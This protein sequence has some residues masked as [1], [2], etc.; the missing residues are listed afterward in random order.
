MG[1]PPRKIGCEEPDELRVRR[2]VRERWIEKGPQRI[3][4]GPQLVAALFHAF[5]REDL[6]SPCSG[7]VKRAV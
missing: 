4:K 7:L 6:R 5:G 1:H 3:E 2:V